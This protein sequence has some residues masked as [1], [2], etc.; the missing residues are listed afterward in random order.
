M[1]RPVL[2]EKRGRQAAAQ[3]RQRATK[4]RTTHTNSIWADLSRKWFRSAAG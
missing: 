4:P 1:S 3:A 2:K